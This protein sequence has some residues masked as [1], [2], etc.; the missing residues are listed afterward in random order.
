MWNRPRS[1]GPLLAL[2]LLLSA[3]LPHSAAAQA[4][5]YTNVSTFEMG[6]MLGTMMSAFSDAGEPTEETV[7]VGDGMMRTDSE[8]QSTIMHMADGRMVQ[9]DHDART[10]WS[11]DFGD[12]TSAMEG[13]RDDAMASTDAPPAPTES[14]DTPEFEGDFQVERTGRTERVAGYSAEQVLF[15]FTM[16]ARD[17]SQEESPLAA[18][19]VLLSEM[20]MSP[21][22]SEH[23]AFQ[24]MNRD[25]MEFVQSEFDT[26]MDMGAMG[27]DPR[28]GDALARMQEELEGLEGMAVRTTSLFV[29]L[30]GDLEFDR[31]AALAALG[32][33]LSGDGPSLADLAGAGAADAARSALG[34]LFGRR[35]EPEEPEEPELTQQALMRMVQEIRDLES[36]DLD[37]AL[38]DPPAD[39]R[40]VESP[41]AGMRRK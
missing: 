40:E 25:A 30:P 9:I 6:G 27:A 18:R 37:P 14:D 28:M 19:M 13:M 5:R 36:I 39:Y 7:W 29:L 22:L 32:E 23:P 3:L 1:F 41:L 21:E 33:E 38:F 4:L 35:S 12:V 11:M 31:D 16:E 17:Q 2:L 8:Q 15:T 34:G 26:G 10:W 20:W 24:A